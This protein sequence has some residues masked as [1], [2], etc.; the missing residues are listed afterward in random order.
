MTRGWFGD[1]QFT[2]AALPT[3]KQTFGNVTYQIYD[4]ATSP[5]P[6]AIMLG[7][8]NVPGNLKE[9]VKGIPVGRKADAL[10]FL[11][12][13]RIDQP[14][15]EQ[16]RRE[17]KR[18]EMLKYVIHYADGQTV[19]V[20][21]YEDVDIAD[22]RQKTPLALP[23]AQ[24]AWTRKFDNSEDSAVAYSKQWNNPR[25]N[26]EIRSVDVVY[27]KDRRGVPALLALSAATAQ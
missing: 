24:F 3:G 7:G 9:E 12:A 1:K 16:D 27:G 5:V 20:P 11:Q 14:L 18:Y 15:N 2:F 13:A 8:P 6:T 17:K 26:V 19:E 25:P 10:F 23:G 4:F 21:I 22:Y